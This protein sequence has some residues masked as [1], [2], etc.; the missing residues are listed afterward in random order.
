MHKRFFALRNG[1]LADAVRK[2]GC[3]CP[4]IYGLNVPQ[5]AAI[6]RETGTDNELAAKLWAEKECRESR[7]LACYLFDPET[8]KLEKAVNLAIDIQ[9]KEEADMLAFRLFKRMPTALELLALLEK[10]AADGGPLA[11]YSAN[12]LKRHLE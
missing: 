8:V 7:L 1:I 5:L 2:A 11:V 4:R 6:A 10:R 12:I 9:S 3:P